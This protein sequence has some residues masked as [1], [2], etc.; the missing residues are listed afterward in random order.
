MEKFYGC[1]VLFSIY[2]LT[3]MMDI[4]DWPTVTQDHLQTACSGITTSIGVDLGCR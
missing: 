2:Q 1:L 3:G 4:H